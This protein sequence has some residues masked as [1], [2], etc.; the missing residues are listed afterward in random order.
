MS[1]HETSKLIHRSL[2][3]GPHITYIASKPKAHNVY[4]MT[5]SATK[6]STA[7]P[8]PFSGKLEVTVVTATSVFFIKHE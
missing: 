6:L 7:I 5:R 4:V 3:F 1:Y 8:A 2:K